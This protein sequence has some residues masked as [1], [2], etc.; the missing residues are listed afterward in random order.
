MNLGQKRH[1]ALFK[2]M[3]FSLGLF[4]SSSALCG[5]TEEELAAIRNSHSNNIPKPQSVRTIPPLEIPSTNQNQS[6]RSSNP[7]RVVGALQVV[8]QA[9]STLLTSPN[10]CTQTLQANH[11]D[12]A[13]PKNNENI[14]LLTG[15]DTKKFIEDLIK[16]L[17][18]DKGFMADEAF[19]INKALITDKGLVN[20]F[21]SKICRSTIGPGH[22]NDALDNLNQPGHY[23][24]VSM[25]DKKVQGFV[26]MNTLQR[27]IQNES[28]K[29]THIDLICTEA[30][31]TGIGKSLIEK[32]AEN[33]E[34]K[35]DLITLDAVQKAIPFYQKQGYFNAES[36]PFVGN[37]H[38]AKLSKN[39]EI[40]FKKIANQFDTLSPGEKIELQ[41]RVIFHNSNALLRD[42]IHRG[43][44]KLFSELHKDYKVN[45]NYIGPDNQSLLSTAANY[46]NVEMVKQLL[47]HPD[48]N[49]SK[50]EIHPNWNKEILN[51]IKLKKTTPADTQ[52]FN[53][54]SSSASAEDVNALIQSGANVNFTGHAD[55]TPLFGA[56]RTSNFEAVGALISHSANVNH[57][58]ENGQTPLHIATKTSNPDMM[59][60]LIDSHAD[61]N[62]A[63][64]SQFTPLLLAVQKENLGIVKLLVSRNADLHH[65]T[66]FGENALD[67]AQDTELVQFLLAHGADINSKDPSGK[68]ALNHAIDSDNLDKVKTL[69]NDPKID[70][71]TLEIE[72]NW[73]PKV[74]QL[75]SE[76]KKRQPATSQ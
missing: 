64:H 26:I 5:F 70:L 51:L 7:R 67:M 28:F 54:A 56:I 55:E 36:D 35:P 32:A 14:L 53:V 1:E 29:E 42:A 9:A 2:A 68:T 63:D 57:E 73:S 22:L 74:I 37:P 65:R 62:H 33:D 72:Q 4:I 38:H 10:S 31:T 58:N 59:H 47:N 17:K 19:M 52:L 43:D 21:F 30:G 25:K 11:V 61:V 50:L 16:D 69:L 44:S 66:L 20:T 23:L 76:A 45:I 18:T 75:V 15:K 27:E 60:F 12:P 40:R 8:N 46:G 39:G 34:I 6:I 13:K 24:M 49:L 3:S 41:N 48:I 71:S